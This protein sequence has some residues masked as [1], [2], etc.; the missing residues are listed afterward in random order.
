MTSTDDETFTL[1]VTSR[2]LKAG[3]TY[4]YKVVGDGTT[5]LPGSDKEITVDADGLYD[6]TFTYKRTGDAVSNTTPTSVQSGTIS[7]KYYVYDNDASL[8]S[9]ITA[10]T[11]K[12]WYQCEM[13]N[14]NGTYVYGIE[15]KALT[16]GNRYGSR[17]VEEHYIDDTKVGTAWLY[18]SDSDGGSQ[19]CRYYDCTADG[20]YNIVLSYTPD[21]TFSVNGNQPKIS[22]TTGLYAANSD[23]WS[24]G[25][26]MDFDATNGVYKY[27]FENI[28]NKY[29]VLSTNANVTSNWS[30]YA[31][32]PANGSGGYNI[33]A[34]NTFSGT[35]YVGGTQSWYLTGDDLN[36]VEIS[37]RPTDYYWEVTPYRTATISSALYATWS[38]GEKYT[39][40]GAEK[41]YTVGANNT[42]SVTLTEKAASTVFPTNEGILVK[43]KENDVVKF[44]A[45]ASTTAASTIGTNYLVGTGNSETEVTVPNPNTTIYVFSWDGANTSS[46]GFYKADATGNLAAHKAYLD[47]SRSEFN[48]R[49]DFLSFNFGEEETDGIDAAKVSVISGTAYNLA[50]QKVGA[51]YKGIVIVNGKKYVRK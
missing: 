38:N 29:F 50:G 10:L 8:W 35:G 33:N 18:V 51:D 9:G 28:N 14:V 21:N 26:E 43:G 13:T 25:V 16:S 2:P 17:F 3:V 12:D 4:K 5:W 15:G 20:T 7:Y 40:S 45:V 24:S 46:V 44:Y 37:F 49:E 32:R 31:I 48:A 47:L 41:I 34:F 30:S 42:S 1:S 23:N 36:N 11:G 6:I 19:G 39:V 22:A 27:T